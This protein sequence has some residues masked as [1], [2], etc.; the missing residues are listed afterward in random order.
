[1]AV[2]AGPGLGQSVSVRAAVRKLVSTLSV[3]LVLDADGLNAFAGSAK[4]LKKRSPRRPPLI[5]TP[6]R[7]EFE[8][9]FGQT[10]PEAPAAR[11]RLAKTLAAEYHVVLVLKGHRTLVTDGRREYVNA[12]GNPGMAKGGTGD[13]LTGMIAAFLAQGLDPFGA[14]AWAVHFHG[15]AGDRLARKTSELSV[16]ASGLLG[17]L[18]AVFTTKG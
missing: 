7:K 4:L 2:A 5:L 8:R 12:T 18:P 3:P 1:M 10:P 6:H 14:A 16:T 13:V 11:R 15:K 17:E 9:L